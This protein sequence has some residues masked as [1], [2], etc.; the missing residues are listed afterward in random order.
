MGSETLCELTQ[1]KQRVFFAFET[2]KYS[3]TLFYVGRKKNT[4]FSQLDV[5]FVYFIF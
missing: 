5:F 3:I 2:L 1:S 4:D